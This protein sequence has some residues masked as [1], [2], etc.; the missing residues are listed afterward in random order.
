LVM[1]ME[2]T[3]HSTTGGTTSTGFFSISQ[4]KISPILRSFHRA[5]LP[6]LI[7]YFALRHGASMRA[8][9]AKTRGLPRRRILVTLPTTLRRVWPLW[10]LP[11]FFQPGDKKKSAHICIFH[12]HLGAAHRNRVWQEGA[13]SLN[14]KRRATPSRWRQENFHAFHS[15]DGLPKLFG[16]NRTP[17]ALTVESGVTSAYLG[18]ENFPGREKLQQ[19]AL[20][21]RQSAV[22]GVLRLTEPGMSIADC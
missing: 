2:L 15:G 9:S 18:R 5:N 7:S 13:D 6:H 11:S 1:S 8:A 20:G 16:G 22:S 19:S 14:V 12:T 4:K 3:L 21:V 10:T 17:R